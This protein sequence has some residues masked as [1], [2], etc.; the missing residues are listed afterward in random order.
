MAGSTHTQTVQVVLTKMIWLFVCS[1]KAAEQQWNDKLQLL[2]AQ[3]SQ[4]C[5]AESEE[6]LSEY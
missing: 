3:F 5:G 1:V 6:K 4:F 2:D